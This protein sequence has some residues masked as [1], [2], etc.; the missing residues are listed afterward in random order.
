ML[1][2]IRMQTHRQFMADVSTVADF[3]LWFRG[4]FINEVFASLPF[5]AAV[6]SSLAPASARFICARFIF[7]LAHT[8]LAPIGSS[9]RDWRRAMGRMAGIQC[10]QAGKLS[11]QSL[12]PR[13]HHLAAASRA[14]R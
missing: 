5:Y 13:P 3:W 12:A 4:P 6:P 10:Q 1:T 14:L 11:Y 7:R 8:A 2:L 9:D